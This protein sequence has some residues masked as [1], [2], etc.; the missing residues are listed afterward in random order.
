L[1]FDISEAWSEQHMT[2][3]Y[4]AASSASRVHIVVRACRR[5]WPQSSS[6]ISTT[7]DAGVA[8]AVV[9]RHARH[10]DSRRVRDGLVL[11][12]LS[13]AMARTS[14]TS[15]SGTSATSLRLTSD[16]SRRPRV[17]PEVTRADAFRFARDVTSAVAVGAASGSQAT[18]P[19]EMEV[20]VDVIAV[21]PV[22]RPDAPMPP[23]FE[24]RAGG[25]RAH[26]VD[27]PGRASDHEH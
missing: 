24:A 9:A 17:T 13:G 7:P 19:G 21:S 1:V 11:A 14:D 3:V 26:R 18:A 12:L 15:A 23:G 22:T 5:E 2:A 6:A 10:A 4:T 16:R 8:I 20:V 25:A 27:R